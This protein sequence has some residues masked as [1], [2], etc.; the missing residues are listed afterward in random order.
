MKE[1]NFFEEQN[2]NDFDDIDPLDEDFFDCDWLDE[3][4]EG[5]PCVKAEPYIPKPQRIEGLT[6]E[7]AE[8]ENRTF[9]KFCLAYYELYR[10]TFKNCTFRHVEL[11]AGRAVMCIFEN[12]EFETCCGE[13]YCFIDCEFIDCRRTGR[14]IIDDVYFYKNCKHTNCKDEYDEPYYLEEEG[15]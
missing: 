6:I 4:E 11:D 13:G 15:G 9:E 5:P 14:E 1:I 10:V 12:C 8:F 7:Q 3:E 2:L